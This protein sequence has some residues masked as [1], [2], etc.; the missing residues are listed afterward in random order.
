[1]MFMLMSVSEGACSSFLCTFPFLHSTWECQL[2]LLLVALC[3]GYSKGMFYSKGVYMSANR[4]KVQLEFP[5]KTFM[6]LFMGLMW[7][8]C[9]M[10]Q[11]NMNS[12]SILSKNFSY[13]QFMLTNIMNGLYEEG[14]CL[15]TLL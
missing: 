12:H 14:V 2:W 4:K 10:K 11:N 13:F 1:M 7:C 5:L 6:V 3:Y 15:L 9:K 8:E